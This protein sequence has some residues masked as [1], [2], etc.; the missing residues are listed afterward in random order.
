MPKFKRDENG[1]VLLDEKGEP[2]LE[3]SAPEKTHTD[4]AF[5]EMRDDMFKYKTGMKE[6]QKQL[7][8]IKVNSEKEQTLARERNNE[9][10]E[11][12]EEE[13]VKNKTL[14][15]TIDEK[16]NSFLNAQKLSRV[17]EKLGSFKRTEYNKFIDTSRVIMDNDGNVDETTVDNEVARLKTEYPE[18]IKVKASSELPDKA[19]ESGKVNPKQVQK[20]S[21]SERMDLRQQ[22][23]E[24]RAKL[25]NT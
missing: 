5:G 21:K 11:L 8:D 19:P 20:M 16:N 15:D 10:K 18:L 24:D 4:K 17:K 12:Y 9:Y 2:I 23:I 22:L 7:D 3:T 13:L 25:Q 14:Q 6:L 1:K